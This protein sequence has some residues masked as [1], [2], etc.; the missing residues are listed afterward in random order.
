VNEQHSYSRR[1]FIG[2]QGYGVNLPVN[3]NLTRAMNPWRKLSP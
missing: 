3:D 1:R 2:L